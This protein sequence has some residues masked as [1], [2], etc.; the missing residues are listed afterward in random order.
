MCS[1]QSPYQSSSFAV[2]SLKPS[3]NTNYHE[4]REVAYTINLNYIYTYSFTL[5]LNPGGA[6]KHCGPALQVKQKHKTVVCK[7]KC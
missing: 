3:R 4:S 7:S 1:K 5:C 6:V 2:T